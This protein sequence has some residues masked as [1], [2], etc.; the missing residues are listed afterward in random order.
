M[1]NTTK[2]VT[3]E[4]KPAEI[5]FLEAIEVLLQRA[6][7]KGLV[8]QSCEVA[9]VDNLYCEATVLVTVRVTQLK[10]P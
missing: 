6:L 9:L 5:T 3:V 7:E 1:S 4:L 2:D 8:S 10:Y